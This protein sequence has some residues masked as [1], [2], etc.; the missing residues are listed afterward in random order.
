M[1]QSPGTPPAAVL[2]RT[3]LAAT[4]SDA[5]TAGPVT[6]TEL[7]ECA[8]AGGAPAALVRE[9]EALPQRTYQSLRDLWPHLSHLP[10]G[11]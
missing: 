1:T 3:E 2:T 11:D 8:E 4:L 9:L 6:R 7:L 5:F 10:V